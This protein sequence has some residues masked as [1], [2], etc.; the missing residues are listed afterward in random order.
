MEEGREEMAAVGG[1]RRRSASADREALLRPLRP[2]DR[3]RL[4]DIVLAAGNFNEAEVATAL[5]LVDEA[6]AKGDASGYFF[7]VLEAAAR[8]VQGYAC[9]G[10]VPLTVGTYDLYWIVVDP[11]AQGRGYGRR[12]LEAV[13][14]R[15]R[16]LGGRKL[17][18][19]TSSQ[20]SYAGTIRFYERSG[21]ELA[22]RI[23]DFYK[24]GDDKLV[25][26]KDFAP[27]RQV[28]T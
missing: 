4:R 18:I 7:L 26:S 16:D 20:E 23:R 24:P 17:L 13:E 28:A 8:A 22:A 15:V 5:E 12:L 21:Y 11:A 3:Q 27:G 19:E 2:G 1:S 9:F 25:F 10:P 14:S 6:L